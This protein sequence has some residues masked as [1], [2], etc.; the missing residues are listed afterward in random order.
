MYTILLIFIIV[1]IVLALVFSNK[2]G[3]A[4]NNPISSI[5]ENF[6]VVYVEPPNWFKKPS[7]DAD[8]WVVAVFPDRIQPDC[9]PYDI[10][11]K[12][13]SLEDLN[14]VSQAYRFWRQ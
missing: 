9:L 8:E 10:T 1:I 6:D 11:D 13:G 14:Y 2:T 4:I 5:S 12:W 3:L 7:Y